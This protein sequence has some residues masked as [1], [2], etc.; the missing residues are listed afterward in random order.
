MVQD[1][2]QTQETI[3]LLIGCHFRFR[4]SDNRFM[5]EVSNVYIFHQ[6]MATESDGTSKLDLF[7]SRSQCYISGF[8]IISPR[9]S[10]VLSKD[11]RGDI[12]Y[13]KYIE[14]FWTN[15]KD[16]EQQFES[17]PRLRSDD[18]NQNSHWAPCSIFCI[19]SVTF[20]FYK[21][22]HSMYFVMMTKCN[23]SPSFAVESL[24]KLVQSFRDYCGR[25]TMTG[26]VL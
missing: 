6:T 26:S 7:Y 8:Y 17:C 21:N 22:T 20:I 25:R 1:H 15:I 3:Y 5:K 11:S 13:R 10:T 19:Q 14:L 23:I 18:V 4:M 24:C 9:G 2:S 16:E 12:P